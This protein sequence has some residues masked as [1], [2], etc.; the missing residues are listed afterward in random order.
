MVATEEPTK[1]ELRQKMGL[2]DVTPERL[3][4]VQVTIKNKRGQQLSNIHAKL[5]ALCIT[6]DT[7]DILYLECAATSTAVAHAIMAAV[8]EQDN[9]QQE[10]AFCPDMTQGFNIH[11]RDG[12]RIADTKLAVKGHVGLH[13]FAL[14]SQGQDFLIA[15][16]ENLWAKLRRKMSCPTYDAWGTVLLPKVKDAGVLLLC[17]SFGLPNGMAV[18]ILD[19]NA[20][21]QFDKIVGEYVRRNGLDS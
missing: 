4:F 2:A 20:E 11:P 16:S 18:Y 1:L 14:M 5:T 7:H 12:M 15:D 8:V 13:H 3:P 17:E 10:W 6:P 21:E 19:L 9:T